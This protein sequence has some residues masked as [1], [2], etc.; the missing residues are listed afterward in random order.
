MDA[1]ANPPHT[2]KAMDRARTDDG[3]RDT[4]AR[5]A[6]DA[7]PGCALCARD[8]P[9]TFHHLIPRTMHRKTR[10]L[11]GFTKEELQRGVDLCRDCHDAVHRFI[12]EKELGERFRTLDALREHPEIAKFVA[13]VRTRG[14]R[15][16]TRRPR[17]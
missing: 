8:R 11:R 14:G 15:H 13:W 3:A 9:L 2:E 4:G 1:R 5:V 17:A 6:R 10:F 16:R 7:V 12:P